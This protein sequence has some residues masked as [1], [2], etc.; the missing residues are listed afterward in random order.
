[1]FLFGGNIF[2]FRLMVYVMQ[3]KWIAL[4]TQKPLKVCWFSIYERNYNLLVWMG[5][6]I[7]M[8]CIKRLHIWYHQKVIYFY[9]YVCS[10][11]YMTYWSKQLF[12]SGCNQSLLHDICWTP[13]RLF[14][15]K[16]IE[17]AIDCWEWLLTTRTDIEEKVL[18][19]CQ[20]F[21]NK[22]FSIVLQTDILLKY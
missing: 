9:C 8:W 12:F 20:V 7:F 6:N 11:M 14:T 18:L 17:I 1:M 13:A 3:W 22:S 16:A 5:N 2:V 4:T 15:K 21:V 19:F 10:I